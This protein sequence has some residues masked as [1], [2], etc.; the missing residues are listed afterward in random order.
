MNK[1][2]SSCLLVLASSSLSL[3][4]TAQADEQYSYNMLSQSIGG[5]LYSLYMRDAA[6][7]HCH[8]PSHKLEVSNEEKVVSW[9]IKLYPPVDRKKAETDLR[10]ALPDIQVQAYS[11]ARNIFIGFFYRREEEKQKICKELERTIKQSESENISGINKYQW[12]EK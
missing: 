3:M 9:A 4:G 8:I 6:S 7:I 12:P 10:S 5:Y 1:C 11:Q 2:L